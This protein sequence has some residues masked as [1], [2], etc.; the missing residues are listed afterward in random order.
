M[1]K[2]KLVLCYVASSINILIGLVFAFID[3][4]PLFAGDYKLMES[5]T[6]S[7]VTYLFR[8]AFFLLIIANAILVIILKVKKQKS[9]LMGLLFNASIVGVGLLSILFYDWFVAVLL[10][11]ITTLTLV[12]RLTSKDEMKSASN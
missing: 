10:V 6:L 1:N 3:I 12:I 7:F 4:R 5:P 11:V 8:A 9:N 2:F